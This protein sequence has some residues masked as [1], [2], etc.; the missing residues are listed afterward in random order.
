M[1]T[2]WMVQL[3]VARSKASSCVLRRIRRVLHCE[4]SRPGK[5]WRANVSSWHPLRSSVSILRSIT[6]RYLGVD[7]RRSARKT[8]AQTAWVHHGGDVPPLV[9]VLWDISD[10]GA[11][12]VIPAP[13]ALPDEFHLLTSR[14]ERPG[15][16]CR[17]VWR[18]GERW[19][20]FCSIRE[21]YAATSAAV[22]NQLAQAR[23]RN[24]QSALMQEQHQGRARS[25]QRDG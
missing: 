10:T 22:R 12:L 19:A 16:R 8:V 11:R 24:R 14:D 15:R 20:V 5:K 18:S 9:C 3:V 4:G 13:E 17:M 21:G 7:R 6:E 25:R 2:S 23:G 1:T